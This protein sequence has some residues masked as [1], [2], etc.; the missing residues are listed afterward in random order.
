MSQS[1]SQI[2]LTK[3]L[4]C[5]KWCF[6]PFDITILKYVNCHLGYTAKLHWVRWTLIFGYYEKRKI[7]QPDNKIQE[8][9]GNGGKKPLIMVQKWIQSRM[10]DCNVS[11]INLICCGGAIKLLILQL[12]RRLCCDEW[13]QPPVFAVVVPCWGAI[14][15]TA[16]ALCHWRCSCQ[17]SKTSRWYRRMICVAQGTVKE[18]S[19]N[20]LSL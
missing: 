14:Q 16:Q 19:L 3:R 2:K 15:G 12:P 5:E 10:M 11:F 8:R 13:A 17:R 1:P 4:V 20:L 9:C 7:V 18:V 6:L